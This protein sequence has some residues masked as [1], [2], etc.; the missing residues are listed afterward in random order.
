MASKIS[1]R[2]R[3]ATHE[4][5]HAVVN[6]IEA[7]P[8]QSV[9]LREMRVKECGQ[10]VIYTEGVVW[11][12]ETR[13]RRAAALDGPMFAGG[14]ARAF[15]AGPVAE[16]LLVGGIDAAV[17]LGMQMDLASARL[18]LARLGDEGAQAVALEAIWNG[19]AEFF[20]GGGGDALR[21]V[22]RRLKDRDSLTCSEVA[23]I[24]ARANE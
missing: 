16:A 21:A 13:A 23:D 19:L 22:A 2:M 6:V 1:N 11:T 12:D 8:F 20:G 7:I 9:S 4:A 24:V 14:W 17:D 18:F 15:L 5:G 3:I 10:T